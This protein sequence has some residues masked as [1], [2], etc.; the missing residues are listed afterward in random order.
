MDF[1]I[2]EAERFLKLLDPKTK[3]FTFQCFHP[4]RKIPATGI[5]QGSLDE[6][7]N[8]L[9]QYNNRG[10]GVYVTINETSG[11]GRKTRDIKN[12]RAVW[13]EDDGEGK[14]LPYKP[15]LV[16]ET[17]PGKFHK[18]LFNKKQSTKKITKEHFDSVQKVIVK[19]YGGDKNARD[20]TRVLRVPGFFNTKPK[21]DRPFLVT[22]NK[23]SKNIKRL[24]WDVIVK[25][26]GSKKINSKK[27][28]LEELDLKIRKNDFNNEEAIS[29]VVCAKSYYEELTSIA[30][31]LANRKL[32]E[33]DIIFYLESMLTASK[34]AKPDQ[35]MDIWLQRYEAIPQFV[36][37]ALD[38][39]GFEAAENEREAN[40]DIYNIL[41]S[42]KSF[43]E[44]RTTKHKPIKWCIEGMLPVGLTIIGGRPKVGKSFLCLDLCDGVS[45]G[46]DV[47]GTVK[48]NEG[49]VVYASMEDFGRRLTKRLNDMEKGHSKAMVIHEMKP[50][51]DGCE[52]LLI[53]FK[54][55]YPKLSM[56]VI[57]TMAHVMPTKKGGLDAYDHFYPLLVS[58]QKLAHQ[59]EIAIV[60]IH[61]LK[62]SNDSDN[63]FDSLLGSVSIQGAV[64]SMWLIKRKPNEVNGQ[65]IMTGRDF[66]DKCLRMEFDTEEL[67]WKVRENMLILS[68]NPTDITIAETINASP[69]KKLTAKQIIKITGMLKGTVS[70]R[71]AKSPDKDGAFENILEDGRNYFVIAGSVV[72]K[73]VQKFNMDKKEWKKRSIR[74]KKEATKEAKRLNSLAM[75][76]K[77]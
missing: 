63:E 70:R 38:K 49:S 5:I 76:K 33:Q 68:E 31:S 57:D 64:D 26:V 67:I 35:D 37:S 2:K 73:E 69:E 22:I 54:E 42:V 24:K 61:H 60:L 48:T 18:Y 56:F 14:K 45:S 23:V 34:Y 30:M 9:C 52:E 21:Y 53:A 59:L 43:D 15:H 39:V 8:T 4:D 29:N 17:S 44:L 47:L 66:G 40:T 50:I 65:F 6:K 11:E 74:R 46:R 75:R 55:R 27:G 62:K 19:E 28:N 12:I 7:W 71:L 20:I 3:E 41:D 1:Q 25:K 36:K 51:G 58:L 72:M 32:K 13:Q 16:V 77:K 10:F